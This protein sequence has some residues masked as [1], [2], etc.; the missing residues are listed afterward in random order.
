MQPNPILCHVRAIGFETSIDES[1]KS[2]IK[3]RKR[4][5]KLLSQISRVERKICNSYLQFQRRKRHL[6]FLSQIQEFF[7]IF[8][9]LENREQKEKWKYF[10]LDQE[11]NFF[12]LLSIF[13]TRLRLSSMPA[14]KK[15]DCGDTSQP[16]YIFP[17][18]W[19]AALIIRSI[20]FILKHCGSLSW[21]VTY[22]YQTN[23]VCG[24]NFATASNLCQYMIAI[25][26]WNL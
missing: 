19:D 2:K 16:F 3:S 26:G 18:A 4:N 5:L 23:S 17:E 12:F 8:L 7:F 24:N 22:D 1:P 9:D 13:F 15:R 11:R 21:K 25:L 20:C 6:K 10:F 14:F